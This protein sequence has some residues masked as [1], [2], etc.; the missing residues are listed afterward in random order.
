MNSS[1]NLLCLVEMSALKMLKSLFF[2][3]NSEICTMNILLVVLVSAIFFVDSWVLFGLV[4]V[5]ISE[6]FLAE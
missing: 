5:T 4:L 6:T 2:F 3:D 1:Y